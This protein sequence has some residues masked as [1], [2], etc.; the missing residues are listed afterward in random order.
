MT[1]DLRSR[2]QALKRRDGQSIWYA[3][4]YD[5]FSGAEEKTQEFV[6]ASEADADRAA[7]LQQIAQLEADVETLQT[8]CTEAFDD[9]V[10]READLAACQ[11]RARQWKTALEQIARCALPSDPT[12]HEPFHDVS[13]LCRTGEQRR[14]MDLAELRQIA[15]DALA[16]GHQKEK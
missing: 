8:K 16:L 11:R 7:L 10:R 1:A 12:G 13:V 15:R 14:L 9:A 2:V 3:I 5:D 6:L 4:E